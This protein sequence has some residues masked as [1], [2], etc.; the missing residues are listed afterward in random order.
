MNANHQSSERSPDVLDR[1]IAAIRETPI[2]AAPADD[3][4][5]AH[6]TEADLPHVSITLWQW[7]KN[8]PRSVRYSIVS[9]VAAIALMF[10]LSQGRQSLALDDVADAVREHRIV[11]YSETMDMVG[12]IT[13]QNVVTLDMGLDHMRIEIRHGDRL[14]IQI[15]DF[16]QMQSLA[17]DPEGKQGH[18]MPLIGTQSAGSFMEFIEQLKDHPDTVRGEEDLD[19]QATVVFRLTTGEET[20]DDLEGYEGV[21]VGG[22]YRT[23]IWVDADTSLPVKIE[24]YYKGPDG[25]RYTIDSNFEWDP[26]VADGVFSIEPPEGYTLHEVSPTE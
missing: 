1:A 4:V 19:G 14:M 9:S 2:P 15:F 10:V 7:I 25:D 11:R 16:E 18:R 23:T 26:E 13:V 20:R 12:A 21:P 5:L 22:P 3:V 24:N 8:M 17:L 6:L